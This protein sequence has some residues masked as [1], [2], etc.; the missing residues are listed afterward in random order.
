VACDYC[1]SELLTGWKAIEEGKKLVQAILKA[2]NQLK[3]P[4]ITE[5]GISD[6]PLVIYFD[7]SQSLITATLGMNESHTVLTGRQA[8]WQETPESS[9][10]EDSGD[11]LD[12]LLEG[13]VQRNAYQALCSTLNVLRRV[14]LFVIFLSTNSSLTHFARAQKYFWSA[15]YRQ[16]RIDTV[17][18]PFIETPFDTWHHEHLLREGAHLLAEVGEP[19]FMVRFSRPLW[20]ISCFG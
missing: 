9:V 14:D 2:S 17:Q 18:A 20:V 11:L 8:E 10:Q 15:R 7:G 16:A 13:R 3:R 12:I 4:K 1:Q 6:V 19:T 5:G